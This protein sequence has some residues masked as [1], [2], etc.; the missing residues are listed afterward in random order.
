MADKAAIIVLSD[1]RDYEGMGRVVNAMIT[2]KEYKDA[3]EEVKLILDGAGTRWIKQF[4]KPDQPYRELYDQ[5]KDKVSVC[6]YCAGAFNVSKEV[7]EQ[8]LPVENEYDGHPS[9]RKLLNEGWKV[10]TF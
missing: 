10:V 4:T 3:G 7:Q 9:I 2:V 1:T 5:V 6:E 8:N